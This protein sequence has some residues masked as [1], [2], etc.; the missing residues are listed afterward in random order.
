MTVHRSVFVNN[1][2]VG[3]AGAFHVYAYR[4]PSVVTVSDTFITGNSATDGGAFYIDWSTL[5]LHNCTI[6]GNHARDSGGAIHSKNSSVTATSTNF[7]GNSAAFGGGWSSS[8]DTMTLAGCSF[9]ENYARLGG[10]LYLLTKSSLA[11]TSTRFVDNTAVMNG[12][13]ISSDN[14]CNTTLEGCTFSRNSATTAGG[15]GGAL[16]LNADNR[17]IASAT[18]FDGNNA[19]FGGAVV[20]VCTNF[21]HFL[22]CNLEKNAATDHGGALHVADGSLDVCQNEGKVVRSFLTVSGCSF[23]NNTASRGG[24]AAYV[25]NGAGLNS[26]SSKFAHN[27]VGDGKGGA[28]LMGNN[29][30]W[31]CS[32]TSFR[33]NKALQGGAVA[34]TQ[35]A[36]ANFSGGCAF[37]SNNGTEEGGAFLVD[38]ARVVLADSM[39]QRNRAAQGGGLLARNAAEVTLG[40][41]VH[42]AGNAATYFGGGMLIDFECAQQVRFVENAGFSIKSMMTDHDT[43]LHRLTSW[44]VLF[45]RAFSKSHVCSLQVALSTLAVLAADVLPT[46][47]RCNTT[48]LHISNST[49]FTGNSAGWAG[50]NMYVAA[51]STVALPT[52]LSATQE[53]WV[54]G[55][56]AEVVVQGTGL[57]A[58]VSSDD[59]YL[60]LKVHVLDA[61]RQPV[62]GTTSAACGVDA[63]MKR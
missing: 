49:K 22:D 25:A 55:P 63:A 27:D 13:A 7:R 45:Y 33:G 39:L 56:V 57:E 17:V 20:S 26:V 54:S 1:S 50:P 21:V 32:N 10:A 3:K 15:S 42:L 60:D 48:K 5:H 14:K 6:A 24:G 43:V 46:R 41:G 4:V 61:W 28:V 40:P 8:N 36:Q 34:V 12:G 62:T 29:S 37:G 16:H 2:V 18:R 51:S 59:V 44:N 9:V 19:T 31:R 30:L 53:Q 35:S 38:R 52:G 58:Y 47:P 23:Q 11:A